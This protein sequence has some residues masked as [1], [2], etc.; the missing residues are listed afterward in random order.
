MPPNIKWN[1]AVDFISV[2]TPELKRINLEKFV[3]LSKE[4]LNLKFKAHLGLQEPAEL[5][6]GKESQRLWDSPEA[7]RV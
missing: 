1:S 4:S 3:Y 6:W 7:M 5:C 2:E